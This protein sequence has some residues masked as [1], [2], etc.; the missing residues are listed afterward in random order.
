MSTSVCEIG[1]YELGQSV[2]TLPQFRISEEEAWEWVYVERIARWANNRRK[3]VVMVQQR[4]MGKIR[5]RSAQMGPSV[6]HQ[7]AQGN[8]AAMVICAAWAGHKAMPYALV[9][10][11]GYEKRLVS[12]LEEREIEQIAMDLAELRN[13]K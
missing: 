11:A 6:T 10:G 4:L 2:Q 13:D 1:V 9:E 8:R 3:N 12:E 5:D 7:A